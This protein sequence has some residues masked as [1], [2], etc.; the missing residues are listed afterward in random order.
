MHGQAVQ[1]FLTERVENVGRTIRFVSKPLERRTAFLSFNSCSIEQSTVPL[2][3]NDDHCPGIP[4]N[5]LRDL[6]DKPQG[7]LAAAGRYKNQLVFKRESVINN[8]WKTG[9]WVIT[10]EVTALLVPIRTAIQSI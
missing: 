4:T 9:V 2:A 3:I 7:S 1:L 6:P 5:R 8:D 10:Q